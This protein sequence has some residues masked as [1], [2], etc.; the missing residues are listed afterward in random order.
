M[1]RASGGRILLGIGVAALALS[2]AAAIN[3]P[4]F[5]ALLG[6]VGGAVAALIVAGAFGAEEQ[7]ASE[8]APV[9]DPLARAREV[10][11][12]LP[13]PMLLLDGGHVALANAP[14]RTLFG[15]WAEGQD[16][17]LALRH[18]AALERLARAGDGKVE[19]LEVVGIGDAERR[20]LLAIAPLSEGWR[21]IH[22]SDRSE[23][24]AAEQMR[25]DFV[26]NASHELRTPL[27]TLLGFIETL[28]DDEAASDRDLRQRFLGI[29]ND[30]AKRMQQLIDDLIT[31]SRVEA[32]RFRPVHE[33]VDLVALAEEVRSGCA[34]LLAER[35][36]R[37]VIEALDGGARVPG[38]RTQLL[39]LVRNL[40]VNAAKYG[41]R[42]TDIVVR[43]AEDGA[44]RLRLSVADQGEGI[45]P[46]HLPR[47]TERFYRVDAGRSR[48]AGGTGLGL[49]IVKHIVGRHRGRLEIKSTLGSGTS[50]EVTLPRAAVPDAAAAVT[51]LSL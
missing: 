47:L 8:D 27:A 34:L 18:P 49:A 15:D 25:I 19:R 33:P 46:E 20:W 23:A 9:A 45:A 35:K 51:S 10:L 40:I 6:L 3:A 22:L 11:E 41:R 13:D 26:A 21:L 48:A 7:R 36:N 42:E 39:Q 44:E 32:E 4:V 16:A 50:V 38:D 17:R 43:I 5:A 1:A 2:G 24:A 12:A 28:R 30:E 37:L 29:M 31:L 14:A